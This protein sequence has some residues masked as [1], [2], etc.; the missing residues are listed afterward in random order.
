[1]RKLII[2][3]LFGVLITFFSCS[4]EKS[5]KHSETIINENG[6]IS[7]NLV[8]DPLFD[9][10][11]KANYEMNLDFI[12]Y[13]DTKVDREKS[14]KVNDDLRNQKFKNIKEFAIAKEEIGYTDYYKRRKTLFNVLITKKG[15]FAK[16]PE[17]A[18]VK[19]K[20]FLDFYKKNKKYKISPND[21][22]NNLEKSE[23]GS[24]QKGSK[25]NKD[26]FRKYN[27]DILEVLNSTTYLMIE[28]SSRSKNSSN[29]IIFTNQGFNDF[30]AIENFLKF[31]K[32]IDNLISMNSF[33]I[34]GIKT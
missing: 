18:Q 5:N 23:K 24:K 27:N 29:P 2:S 11:D 12:K 17:L 14:E 19:L 6:Q 28:L 3:F 26:A 31:E 33:A 1:M 13:S 10:F 4:K 7:R 30:I 34:E 25:A 8:N 22:K 20:N 16:Y 9:K 32:F 15:L 21:L